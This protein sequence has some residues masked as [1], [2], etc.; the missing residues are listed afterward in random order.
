M[1]QLW[2]QLIA[3][4]IPP[5]LANDPDTRRLAM[6]VV[7]FG[8]SP[9]LVAPGLSLL[10][11]HSLEPAVAGWAALAIL[12]TVPLCLSVPVVLRWSGSI[13]LTSHV[14]CGYAFAL[15]AVVALL[16]GARDAPA[17]YWFP[18]LPMAVFAVAGKRAGA[19][20]LVLCGLWY[21]ATFSAWEMG[22]EFHDYVLPGTQPLL[23]L[24][25]ISGLTLLTLTHIVVF[26]R[27]KDDAVGRLAD[28]NAEL[29][30]ARDEAQRASQ[31]KSEF[32]ANVSHE[33]RT[34]M[35]AILGLADLLSEAATS[36]PTPPFWLESLAIVRH[37]GEHL[38]AILNDIL[39]LSKVESGHLELEQIEFSLPRLLGEAIGKKI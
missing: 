22:V 35:T 4:F 26:E 17:Q 24:G 8:L 7:G 11:W 39:D 38:L 36:H 13:E 34:P 25:C 10:Y 37:N 31:A 21:V 18:V 12:G 30:L 32:L 29:L 19:I 6:I 28:T 1:T 33:V 16:T 9:A 27:V 14:A 3:A 5:A 2:E 23:W 20:W 15:L